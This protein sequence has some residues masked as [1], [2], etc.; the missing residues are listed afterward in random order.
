L[1]L[2]R[3]AERLFANKGF[4]ATTVDEIVRQAHVSKPAFYRHYE[5]KKALHMA[6]LERHREELAVAALAV[7]EPR[8]GD[9]ASQLA[10]AIDAWFIHVEAH[11][12][13]WR[14]LFRDTTHDPELEALHR[15][16]QRRQ[17]A[18]DVALLRRF[19]PS[20]PPAELEPLAEMIRSS[21]TGL[22][23]WWL[24]HPQTPR[25]VLVSALLRVM[26]GFLSTHV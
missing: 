11:P 12:Y 17:R 16:L 8:S 3:E 4:A 15:E 18:T 13:A 24:D 9:L 2:E 21:L 1:R 25:A 14:L 26:R 20:L 7:L 5:S 23:L 19:V 6:L 22:A 10:A